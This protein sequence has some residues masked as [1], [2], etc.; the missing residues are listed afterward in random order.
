MQLFYYSCMFKGL[1]IKS[2]ISKAH[3]K[4]LDSMSFVK[5]MAFKFR[6]HACF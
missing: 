4:A 6:S 2:Y 5:G 3:S 1:M